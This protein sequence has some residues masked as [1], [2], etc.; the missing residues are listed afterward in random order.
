MA[1]LTQR[2]IGAATLRVATYEEVEAASDATTEAMAVVLLASAAFGIG[3]L[4]LG[5][6]DLSQLLLG[7]VIALVQWIAWAF[8][9]YLIGTRILPESQTE[10]DVGQLLR[11]IGF[12]AS[13]G[14]LRVLM[15]VPGMAVPVLAVTQIWMLVAMVVGVRQA[16]DYSSTARAVAV[17]LVGF[18]L[19]LGMAIVIG[20]VFAPTVS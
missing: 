5:R 7:M 1:S 16:L 19:S 10:A 4:G 13:P 18:V 8:L 12:A 6:F 14:I 3:T 2:M 17:C 9:T 15:I 11:T 20:V